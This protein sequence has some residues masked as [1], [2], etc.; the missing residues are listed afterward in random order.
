MIILLL[1]AQALLCLVLLYNELILKKASN[2]A[3]CFFYLVYFVVYIAVPIVL[4]VSF[5]GARSIV[6]G[7]MNPF[8]GEEAYV[9]FNVC[10]IT[11]LLFALL[12]SILRKPAQLSE[13]V[14][15]RSST[16]DS[17]VGFLIVAGYFVFLYSAQMDFSELLRSSRF[18]WT[19]EEPFLILVGLLSVYLIAFTPFYIYRFNISS[20]GNRMILLSCIAAVVLYGVVTKDRKWI[21]YLLSGWLAARYD[22][23]GGR[24]HVRARH[25]VFAATLFAILYVTNFARDAVPRYLLGGDVDLTSEL[26]SWLADSIQFGD[27]SYFYRATIEAIHQNINNNFFVPLA[28]M[29]RIV[30]FFLPAGYSAGLKIEDISAI[31]SDLVGGGDSLRRGSMPPGLFGLFFISFGVAVTIMVM[32]LLAFFV[33]WLDKL[34]RDKKGLFRDVML[35][36]YFACVV[37]AFRGDESTAFYLPA[38]NFLMLLLLQYVTGIKLQARPLRA[39]DGKDPFLL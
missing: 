5:G 23:S 18:S 2:F 13:F 35:S 32:P 11:L 29:R 38:V 26:Q 37:Y 6:S 27:L 10:G 25:V 4:H 31:F 24:I 8:S 9:L 34:F 20:K 22:S 36:F 33:T 7:A 30:F 21:F 3:T 1:F 17:C 12:I 16:Y 19:S 28:L 39:I 14:R 15:R